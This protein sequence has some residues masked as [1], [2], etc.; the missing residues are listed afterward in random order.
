MIGLRFARTPVR[1]AVNNMRLYFEEINIPPGEADYRLVFEDEFQQDV[2][3][4]TIMPHMHMRARSMRVTALFEGGR[5]RPL[6][7]VPNWDF[8]WQTTYKLKEPI[9]IP[10]GTRIRIE[11]SYDNSAD[12]PANPDPTIE[13]V[14]GEA[15]TDEMM[16]AFIDYTVDAENILE[17]RRIETLSPRHV[18]GG[19]VTAASAE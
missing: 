19:R 12:N 11:A 7:H 18:S 15:T 10:A 4:H 16:V 13:V 3:F 1:Q 9:S 2:H 17:G 8:N 14:S 5:E 6:L